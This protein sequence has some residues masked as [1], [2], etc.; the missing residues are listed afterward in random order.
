MK[1]EH[2]VIAAGVF[3]TYN[4]TLVYKYVAS[5]VS[6]LND[7]P[8]ECL[9]FH[10]IRMA[11]EG[12]YA[13]FD[14]G[15]SKR[16]QEGLRQFKSKWGAVEHDVHMEYITGDPQPLTEDSVAMKLISMAI[17]HSPSVVCRMLG[18]V[19]YRYSQ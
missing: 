13:T 10:A 19:F 16:S 15:I 4:D 14:F 12:G 18:E 6:A 7:R 5:D 2:S 11:V 1:N 8:N 3:L 9:V 17:K